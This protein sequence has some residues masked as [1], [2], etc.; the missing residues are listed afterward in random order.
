VAPWSGRGKPIEPQLGKPRFLPATPSRRSFLGPQETS[1]F[2]A[3]FRLVRTESHQNEASKRTHS[4]VTKA[5]VVEKH[6]F[7]HVVKVAAVTG[8]SPQR[9]AALLAVAYG[10]G[11]Q[12]K[13]VALCSFLTT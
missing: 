6:Q 11:L 10:L 12:S 9:D 7:A 13:E 8:Q 3:G 1:G 5:L 2:R 4:D